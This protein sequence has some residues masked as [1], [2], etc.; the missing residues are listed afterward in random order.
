MR[1]KW[2]IGE[3]PEE[4]KPVIIEKNAVVEVEVNEVDELVIVV[5]DETICYVKSDGTAYTKDTELVKWASNYYDD[6][7][8]KKSE[9][10]GV[11]DSKYRQ[12]EGMDALRAFG[13]ELFK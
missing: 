9:D 3:E 4:T 5:N 11:N 8:S 6:I 13:K 10:Y 7:Y 1:L 2:I 12:N